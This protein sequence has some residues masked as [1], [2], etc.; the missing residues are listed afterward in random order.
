MTLEGDLADESNNRLKEFKGDY[1]GNILKLT[2]KGLMDVVK[3]K[4]TDL[5][6]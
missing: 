3:N 1:I 5:F 6:I 2:D 4:F